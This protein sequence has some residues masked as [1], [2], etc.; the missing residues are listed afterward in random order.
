MQYVWFW[1]YWHWSTESYRCGSLLR[2]PVHAIGSHW[3]EWYDHEA[4]PQSRD[5]IAAIGR[6][7]RE[8]RRF[9]LWMARH[10]APL[11][12]WNETTPPI[13]FVLKQLA[14]RAPF[15]QW[16]AFERYRGEY[17]LRGVSAIVIDAESKGSANDVRAVEAI[18]LPQDAEPGAATIVTEGFD[19]DRTELNTA[20]LA[21]L[22]LLSGGGLTRLL[23][24]WLASGRRPYSRAVAWSLTSGWLLTAALLLFLLVGPDPRSALTPLATT[25]LALWLA[26]VL[27]AVTVMLAVARGARRAG[28]AWRSSLEQGQLRL[29]MDGGLKVQGGS[30]GLPLVLNT[31]LAITRAKPEFANDSWLW[32]RIVARLRAD[33]RRWAATGVVAPSGALDAVVLD[34]KL[35][36]TLQRPG[37]AHVLT[38]HQRDAT[39]RALDLQAELLAPVSRADAGVSNVEALASTPRVGSG[40]TIKQST[41]RPSRL[42]FASTPRALSLH[43][44]RH[45]AQ[46]LFTMA[47][48]RSRR[49]LATNSLAVATS[50]VMLLALPDLKSL[51]S[52]PPAPHVVRPASPS[53]YHL[54]V[55]LDTRAPQYFSVVFESEF[56]ANR[57]ANV[58]VYNGANASVRA[59][60]R[61]HRTLRPTTDD[62][63]NG[64]VWIERR[65][66][67]LSRE[68][69][70]GQ[71]VGRYTL[72]HVNG[73]ADE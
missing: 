27:V 63:D 41:A 69:E 51:V 56:W 12:S 18:L 68:F 28:R 10:W 14:Q 57:R 33:A 67:L 4:S 15:D 35:R 21:A 59:E 26:L 44:S 23:A 19:A 72:A 5:A 50:V 73:I 48:L 43:R 39:T 37:I 54:W 1:S 20:R 6:D 36:A 22:N 25:L 55:S 34:A 71:R 11:A 42:A 24:I 47:G 2:G 38:P 30:A 70:P 9:V 31:V 45:V 16:A 62:L 66:R 17:G 58:Y 60:L 40:S 29:H 52:P 32:Q 46:S 7:P 65:R 64:T 8:Q 53:P 49:Q 3:E 61:L 13:R